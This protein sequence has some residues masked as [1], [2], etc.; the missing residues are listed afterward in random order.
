VIPGA[1][2]LHIVD[3]NGDGKVDIADLKVFMTYSER[4][5]PPKPNAGK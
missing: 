2:I 5:N 1:S 3:F 4:E